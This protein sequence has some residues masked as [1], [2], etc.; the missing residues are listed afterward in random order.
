MDAELSETLPRGVVESIARRRSYLTLT[1]DAPS[2]SDIRDLIQAC[3][4]VADHKAL[5]PWRIITLRGAARER[6]GAAIVEHEYGDASLLTDPDKIADA[7]KLAGKP[8]RAPLLIAIVHRFVGH[9]SVPEWEQV[10]SAAG[11]GHLLS[12]ALFDQGWGVVWRT[13]PFV[14]MPRVAEM[15]GLKEGERLLGW[16][17]VGGIDPSDVKPRNRRIDAAQ[18]I[19]RLE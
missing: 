9:P 15:H 5:R 2:D 6:F 17:Y 11:L 3:T 1:S 10:A 8:L 18:L 4:S 13:G 19:T 16:L 7:R 14:N 12:L